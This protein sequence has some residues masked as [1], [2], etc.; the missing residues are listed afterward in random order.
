MFACVMCMDKGRACTACAQ[1]G[2]PAA[3]APQQPQCRGHS[4]STK[5]HL[6]TQIATMVWA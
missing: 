5:G 3:G 6:A 2:G 4:T 1:A